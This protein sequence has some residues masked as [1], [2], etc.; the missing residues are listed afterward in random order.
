[1]IS[2]ADVAALAAVVGRAYIE[3]RAALAAR[4]SA[5]RENHTSWSA[6]W[7]LLVRPRKILALPK[8]H[9]LWKN[10]KYLKIR[11][12]E[13]YCLTKKMHF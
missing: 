7:V 13:M 1:M 6:R 8:H 12:E 10:L 11:R 9:N 3:D 5:G 4:A 2:S